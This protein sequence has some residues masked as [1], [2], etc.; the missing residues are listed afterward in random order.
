MA[1][2]IGAI[3]NGGLQLGAALGVSIV[4]SISQSIESKETGRDYQSLYAGLADSFTFYASLCAFMAI[5][6]FIFFKAP[7]TV[8]ENETKI[9]MEAFDS[10]DSVRQNAM[11]ITL[12]GNSSQEE[13]DGNKEE[14]D[15]NV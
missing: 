14:A 4:T 2:T 5:M 10:P 7:E 9:A 11:R 12:E 13:V 8:I 1:G 15:K 6:T 3:F